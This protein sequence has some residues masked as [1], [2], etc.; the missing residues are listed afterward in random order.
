[1]CY[2]QLTFTQ[3]ILLIIEHLKNFH[4]IVMSLYYLH[5]TH[6][7]LEWVHLQ[8]S[9]YNINL[10]TLRICLNHEKAFLAAQN[11]RKRPQQKA[12]VPDPK[13]RVASKKPTK[14]SDIMKGVEVIIFY[15]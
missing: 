3:N 1:M 4:V 10:S 9:K 8:K 2:K 15:F 12:N 14:T 5:I 6:T 7:C 11:Q 13:F